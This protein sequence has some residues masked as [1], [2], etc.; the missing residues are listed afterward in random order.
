MEKEASPEGWSEKGEQYEQRC[1]GRM[2]LIYVR[3]SEGI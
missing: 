2:S 1:G 3:C